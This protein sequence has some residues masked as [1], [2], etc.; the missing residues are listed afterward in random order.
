MCI[1][2]QI[3]C[4]ILVTV[5]EAERSFNKLENSLKTKQRLTMGQE[6][7]NSLTFLCMENVS[8]STIHFDD[9]INEFVVL[10]ARKKHFNFNIIYV[11]HK[12]KLK[13]YYFFLFH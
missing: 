9:V 6:R 2:L 1:S 8:A 12:V 4:T 5:A 3:F 7:L 10:K 13:K 11:F